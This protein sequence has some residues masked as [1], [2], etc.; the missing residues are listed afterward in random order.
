MDVE[1]QKRGCLGRLAV[2]LGAV[3]G[4][5]V[6]LPFVLPVL[7]AVAGSAALVAGMMLLGAVVMIP[8]ALI[9]RC[10]VRWWKR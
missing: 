6:M 5:L 7:G 4:V 9:I 3:T 2:P 1:N 10:G 8:A